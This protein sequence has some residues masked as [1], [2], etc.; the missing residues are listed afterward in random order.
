MKLLASIVRVCA[1]LLVLAFFGARDADAQTFTQTQRAA[2]E[3]EQIIRATWPDHEE[4]AAL[5]VAYRESGLYPAAYNPSSGAYCLFQFL[6]STAYG[7]GA[8]YASLADPWY[9]SAQAAR[10]QDLMGWSPWAATYY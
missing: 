7:I 8:D 3:V 2:P 6:P 4:D 5:A 10:L 1:V 9:C